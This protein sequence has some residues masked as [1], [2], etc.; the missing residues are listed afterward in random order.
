MG[1]TP[2]FEFHGQER[3]K[4]SLFWVGKDCQWVLN[5][6]TDKEV[7]VKWEGYNYFIPLIR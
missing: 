1:L 2:S 3:V 4:S 7:D 5:G 6:L